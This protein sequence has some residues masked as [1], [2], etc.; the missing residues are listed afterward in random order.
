V[1]L[2]DVRAVEDVRS[3]FHEHVRSLFI[4]RHN[5]F[6]EEYQT[7]LRESRGDEVGDIRFDKARTIYRIYIE[8]IQMFDHVII[9]SG[10][11]EE[12]ESQ[13]IQIVKSLE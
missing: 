9:N 2:N 8:N 5:P 1:I 3:T 13:I 11:L 6:S 10:S 12:L 4:F 7:E